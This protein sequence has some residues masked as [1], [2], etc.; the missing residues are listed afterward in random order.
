[1]SKK[2][3]EEKRLNLK[4]LLAKQGFRLGLKRFDGNKL[5]DVMLNDEPKGEKYVHWFE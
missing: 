3:D 5:Y 2:E 4:E 1:M